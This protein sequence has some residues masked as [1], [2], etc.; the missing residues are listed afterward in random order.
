M[1]NDSEQFLAVVFAIGCVIYG[2]IM[3]IGYVFTPSPKPLTAKQV[4]LNKMQHNCKARK[5]KL[6]IGETADIVECWR[7]PMFREPKLQFTAKF[8][9]KKKNHKE[10]GWTSKLKLSF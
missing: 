9:E 8:G 2:V 3:G 1:D 10:E 7:T 4:W 5:S 6:T